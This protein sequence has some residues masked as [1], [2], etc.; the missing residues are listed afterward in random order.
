VARLGRAWPERDASA[1]S[2]GL[3]MSRPHASPPNAALDA[4]A[5]LTAC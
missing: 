5:F 3:T 4:T 1:G 2:F